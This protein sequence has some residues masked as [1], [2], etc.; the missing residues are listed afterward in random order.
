MLRRAL[1]AAALAGCADPGAS[2]AGGPGGDPA[3][4]P[5]DSAAFDTGMAEPVCPEDA[6]YAPPEARPLVTWDAS[7]TWTLDFDATAEAAGFYDC[8][9]SRQY[10]GLV[11]DQRRPGSAPAAGS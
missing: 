6:A 2:S 1:T 11:E 5:G 7:F 9:Y 10:E 3:G 8:S 4:G